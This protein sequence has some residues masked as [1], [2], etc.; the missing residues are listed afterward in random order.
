[1]TEAPGIGRNGDGAC[2]GVEGAAGG[3]EQAQALDNY[4]NG[5]KE[6][7]EADGEEAVAGGED[8]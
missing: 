3:G 1:M 2:G 5:G 6:A 4:E 7:E 8:G